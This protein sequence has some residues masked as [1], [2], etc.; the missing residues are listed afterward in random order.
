MTW[1][2]S[3]VAVVAAAVVAAVPA[4]VALMGSNET[5]TD[6]V[7][8]SYTDDGKTLSLGVATASGA[9]YLKCPDW[10]CGSNHNQV[11]L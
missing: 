1:R 11:L 4:T 7:W 3:V 9:A 5:H 6:S 10:G 2:E 8:V